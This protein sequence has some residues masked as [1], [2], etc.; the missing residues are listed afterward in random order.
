MRDASPLFIAAHSYVNPKQITYVYH[1]KT[2]EHEV[3]TLKL[4]KPVGDMPCLGLLK[5]QVQEV[6]KIIYEMILEMSTVLVHLNWE[7]EA[8]I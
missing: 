8:C 3:V 7:F 1:L 2:H 6:H 5:V 4:H